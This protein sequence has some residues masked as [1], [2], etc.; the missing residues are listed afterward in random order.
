MERPVYHYQYI[1]ARYE[2]VLALL[3][4]RAAVVLQPATATATDRA[5][6]VVSTLHVQL[7]RFEVGRE[8]HVELGDLAT[9]PH[10]RARLP[11]SWRAEH[12]AT[13]FPSVEAKLEI[14]ALSD[15]PPTTQIWLVGSYTPP[16][17]VAGGV[18][19]DALGHRVAEA[20]V[21]RFVVDAVERIREELGSA[22]GAE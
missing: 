18:A 11:L 16:L 20:A 7:G 12:G 13:F 2:D 14:A 4:D 6:E 10:R 9:E 8:V 1:P 22:S 15:K 19:N 21:H 5:R 3:Q 17:G